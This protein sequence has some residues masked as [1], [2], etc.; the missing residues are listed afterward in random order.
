[1]KLT[2]KELYGTPSIAVA[3]EKKR[4]TVASHDDNGIEIT[5]EGARRLF[6]AKRKAGW[7]VAQAAKAAKCEIFANGLVV[8]ASAAKSWQAREAEI[9]DAL[10]A[11]EFGMKPGLPA[12]Y[13]IL[14]RRQH[15][16]GI[17]CSGGMSETVVHAVKVTEASAKAARDKTLARRAVRS[18]QIEYDELKARAYDDGRITPD[19]ITRA[20]L[21]LELAK[22]ALA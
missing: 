14:G 20:A 9:G 22:E 5:E 21:K 2:S 1:M 12:L 19:D 17:E 13:L 15:S 18:A 4:D 11:E 3:D 16:L 6:A 7:K 10:T 8:R